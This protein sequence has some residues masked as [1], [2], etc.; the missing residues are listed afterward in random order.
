MLGGEK[1]R[2]YSRIPDEPNSGKG[3]SF[4]RLDFHP[5]PAESD[6]SLEDSFSD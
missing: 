3:K 4:E 5:A 1:R 2:V 6:N